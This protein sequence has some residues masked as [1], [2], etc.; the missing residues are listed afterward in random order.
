MTILPL[1]Q[2]KVHNLRFL[3]AESVYM[4][5]LGR[6]DKVPSVISESNMMSG[7]SKKAI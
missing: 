4:T 7:K 1:L 6:W 2:P 3:L 5:E